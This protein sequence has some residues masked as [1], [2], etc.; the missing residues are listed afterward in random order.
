MWEVP[1]DTDILTKQMQV[2]MAEGAKALAEASRE[3]ARDVAAGNTDCSGSQDQPPGSITPG[4]GIS[5]G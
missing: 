2:E 5:M 3:V 1:P 4:W